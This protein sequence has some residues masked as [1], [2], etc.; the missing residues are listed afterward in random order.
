MLLNIKKV[1]ATVMEMLLYL[2][3]GCP[4]YNG[5]FLVHCITNSAH[6]IGMSGDMKHHFKFLINTWYVILNTAIAYDKS[7]TKSKLCASVEHNIHYI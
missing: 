6:A 7:K 2:L 1:F 3:L 5:L 4:C